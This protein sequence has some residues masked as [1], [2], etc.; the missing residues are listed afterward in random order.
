[1]KK[2]TKII[3]LLLTLVMMLTMGLPVSAS[4]SF[5]DV[6]LDHDYY[7]AITNLSSE[8]ILN[9]MGDGTFAPE[10]SVT[11]AQFT[12]IICYALSMGSITYSDAEKSIFTDVAPEHWA[13]NNI[14]TGYKQGIING[15][16]DGTFAPEAGVNYEQA[17]KMV[18]C[19]LG[20]TESEANAKGG[21]PGG[22]MSIANSAK[23]LKGIKDATVGQPMNR[24]S[25]AQLVDNMMDAEQ[26]VDGEEVGSLRDQRVEGKK[27][28]G[29]VVAGYGVSLETGYTNNCGK[30]EIA[31][32]TVTGEVIFDIDG[33]DIDIYDY[34]GRSVIVYYEEQTAVKDIAT[35]I[36]LQSKKNQEIK[37]D[38]GLIEPSTVTSTSF[39]YYSDY[40][41][42]DI[43]KVTYS[44]NIDCLFN[45]QPVSANLMTLIANNIGKPGH[46]TLVSSEANSSAD[47]AFVKSY[48]TLIVS[49][50]DK[51]AEK[52]FSKNSNYISTALD[53]S[54]NSKEVI[55]TQ[56]GSPFEFSSIQ[57]NHILSVAKD[58]NGTRVEVLVTGYGNTK[59]GTVQSM[60]D[61]NRVILNSGNE[62][63]NIITSQ[64]EGLPYVTPAGET[65][66]PG[67]RVT[68]SFDAFG[69]VV[70]YQL[71]AEATLN[72]GYLSQ[73]EIDK[74]DNIRVMVYKP[75]TSNS[76]IKDGT[77]FSF[78]SRVKIDGTPYSVESDAAAIKS[79]LSSA[80]SAVNPQINGTASNMNT[81]P[82]AQPIRYTVN[83]SNMIDSIVTSA[84]TGENSVSL[85]IADKT[86]NSQ[87]EGIE[88]TEDG[89]R[90]EGGIEIS[91]STPIIY[92]PADRSAGN[93][94]NKY[95]TYSSNMFKADGTEYYIQFANLSS[96]NQATVV[97]YYGSSAG[98]S[99]VTIDETVVPM[100]ITNITE[101]SHNIYGATDYYELE[102][103][104]TG[105]KQYFYDDG[106]LATKFPNEDLEI[107]DIVRVLVNSEECPEAIELVAN[108]SGIK[109][110]SFSY[111]GSYV[112]T[113]G[114]GT[115]TG[116]DYCAKIGV[117]KVK[118][119]DNFTLV[120]GYN[121]A[122]TSTE[123]IRTT[124]TTPIYEV[125][126][127]AN[128]KVDKVTVGNIIPSNHATQETPVSRV[129]VYASDGAVKAV[130]IFK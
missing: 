18:V 124:S 9:G 74:N 30:N 107:G 17:V 23:I 120:E 57:E 58:L 127:A 29:K 20:Y 43:E 101:K 109:A 7:E 3:S 87:N 15:M 44:S 48:E 116:A 92:I 123:L 103:I 55:I 11:R 66:E 13:A 93:A 96:L 113:Q 60:P 110:G 86:G 102:N 126:T 112:M 64:S 16:G 70:K 71:A 90:F 82:Y 26:I 85:N 72:Y 38:L 114:N 2:T 100:I 6:P 12:K 33:L 76:T 105:E 50:I 19:A 80:A 129:F 4:S 122:G 24:G 97:Y 65:L 99:T 95:K 69:N 10:G 94:N 75:S 88:C 39:E 31:L 117:V 25:V 5:S 49:R 61:S 21:Y 36:A 84:T 106:S 68:L 119:G 27:I 35:N 1:M 78:A 52:V 118:D 51:N 77:I 32:R 22:Y 62:M 42:S 46:I 40:N 14:V 73:L 111:N 81:T 128:I 91:S 67:K 54:D 104:A 37:I 79:A 98:V 130:V 41:Y 56:N 47:V 8:G 28:E 125:D 121:V 45:G 83:S 59:S 115:G 53:L 63:F 89:K 108:A 34:L